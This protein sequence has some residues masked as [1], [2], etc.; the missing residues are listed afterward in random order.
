MS[1]AAMTPEERSGVQRLAEF[2]QTQ[3]TKDTADALLLVLRQCNHDVEQAAVQLLDS[4]SPCCVGWAPCPG[5][6]P[7]HLLSC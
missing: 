6:A 1:A 7:V 3:F 5:Q 4:A 2:T